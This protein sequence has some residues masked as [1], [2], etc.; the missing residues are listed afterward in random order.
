MKV[1]GGVETLTV[2][3]AEVGAHL[4]V[5]DSQGQLLVT[6]IADHAGNA[7]LAYVPAE[8]I[9]LRSQ[10]DLAEALSD[11]EV[12][13]PGDYTVADV[14][15]LVL[16]VDD[17]AD[18]S[19]Y[20]QT[21]SPGFG[22]LRVRDGVDLSI[23]VSFPDENLYGAG[24]Y[25]TVIEYSG[26]GPSNP[27][28][29]QPG[30]LIANLMGFAVVGVNMR[31]TGCSGGVFDIFSPAQAADGYDAIET[32]ARQPWV[33]HNHVGMVGLSYPGIS[34]LYVAATRP[35]SLAA[36]TPLSVIDDLWR[37]QWPGG[38]YNAGFTR[39]WLVARDKE[40]AA[41]GMTWDQ[42][43]IDAG[44]KVA[45]QNQM[46]RTQNFDF[47]QFGRAIENFRPT[48]GARRA[49]SLVDQI[50]VPVYLTGAWQDEQTGSRFALMLESFDSSPSQRFN[51]FNGHHPDGYSPMV[52]LRWFEF[53]SFH[54]A[55]RVPVVPEL[56][57][58]FAPLQFA[59]VFGYDAELESDRFGH[60]A[61]DFEAAFAE[62]LA[63]P[64]VRILFESGAGHEVIG[65]TAHRYEAQTDSFPPKGVKPR[66]WYFAEGAALVESAPA[67]S[68]ADS[69]TDDPDAGELAYSMELLSDLDQFTRPKVI[70][71]WTRFADSHRVAYQ[72]APLTESVLIA[73]SGHVDLW[74]CAGSADTAVQVTLTEVRPD[75]MEQRLQCGWHRPIHAVEDPDHS[76]ELRV[77]YTF[78]ESDREELVSGEWKRFRIPIH[79]IAH[80]LRAGSCLRVAVSTPGRD[81]PF[82]CFENPVVEGA[83]HLVGR[84]EDHPSSLVLPVWSLDLDH[85]DD[86]PPA[87][88]LRGQPSRPAEAIR[89]VSVS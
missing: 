35:P 22:Y 32:V 55:R 7:H 65:A 89:N 21:L 71:D 42:E 46:I 12:L 50:E 57:R 38:I 20:E 3:G 81:H 44:D 51:L 1:H 58:S 48:M 16:A 45:K 34:Q 56:I 23:L 28:A 80:L 17:I 47:E 15:V 87:G 43:R 53:L 68:G 31:G 79:P 88:S 64:R 29:P 70:I 25:P 84:S 59:Q 83:T 26:Y 85:P 39:A 86:Y 75:G 77:D 13:A 60:H 8:P 6:L 18:P 36:I 24:P 37:Q 9:V 54:V 62:Y 14:P 63:E 33:L 30:T 4:E 41:G 82:W 52:I 5:R 72:T 49:A 69:Y 74:M 66:R 76:D 19:V 61:D 40:S 11:G 27:D 78:L 73:G 67:G 2:T 10:Q